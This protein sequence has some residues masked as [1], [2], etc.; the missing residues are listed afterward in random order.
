MNTPEFSVE[1]RPAK[2]PGNVKAHAD[3][4]FA[5][6][7]GSLE[8]LGF[9]VIEQAGKPPWVGFPARPGNT[10]GK[11]FPIVN[12]DGALKERICRSILEAYRKAL[13]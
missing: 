2:K 4:K 7:G 10:P 9:P 12:A 3:L 11:F 5:L 6:H 8:V 13:P 1:I